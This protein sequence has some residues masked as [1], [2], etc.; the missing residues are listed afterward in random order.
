M[1]CVKNFDS[2]YLLV[3]NEVDLFAISFASLDLTEK[4]SKYTPGFG[5]FIRTYEMHLWTGKDI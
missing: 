4:G 3:W 5:Q 1:V 2:K